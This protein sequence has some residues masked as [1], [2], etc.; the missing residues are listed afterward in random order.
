MTQQVQLIVQRNVI[1][2]ALAGRFGRPPLFLRLLQI[3]P[4]L[5]RLPARLVGIGFRPEH[6]GGRS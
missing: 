5:R 4:V 1:G 2:P 6:I 3:F